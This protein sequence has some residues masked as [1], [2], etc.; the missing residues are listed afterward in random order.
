MVRWTGQLGQGCP[1]DG[2]AVVPAR[3][4]ESVHAR[5]VAERGL[6]EKGD[7]LVRKLVTRVLSPGTTG[8]S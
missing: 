7:A 4:G 5:M 3:T 1:E 8:R 2:A 6:T